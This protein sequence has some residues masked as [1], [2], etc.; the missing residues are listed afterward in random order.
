MERGNAGPADFRRATAAGVWS[1]R[2]GPCGPR[3]GA[4]G[5]T[6]AVMMAEK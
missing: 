2:W 1:G 5:L 3:Q 6:T 4:E